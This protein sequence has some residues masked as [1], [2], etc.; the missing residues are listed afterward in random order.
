MTPIVRLLLAIATAA[1][2]AGCATQ[3]TRLDAQWVNPQVAGQRTV[4]SLMVMGVSR[5]AT[6]CPGIETVILVMREGEPTRAFKAKGSMVV[7]T[8]PAIARAVTGETA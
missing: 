6:A 7:Q 1:T 3:T 2:V 5:D 4:R 8:R